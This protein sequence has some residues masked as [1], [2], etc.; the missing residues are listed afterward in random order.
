MMLKDREIRYARQR[1]G[2]CALPRFARQRAGAGG[3]RLPLPVCLRPQAVPETGQVMAS[4]HHAPFACLAPGFCLMRSSPRKLG[5]RK[6][7]VPDMD[8]WG[9]NEVNKIPFGSPAV[10]ASSVSYRLLR[11]PWLQQQTG[12]VPPVQS[13][14]TY[15]CGVRM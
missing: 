14:T 9:Q 5:L 15:M 3:C 11:G 12:R 1:A 7:W 6:V 2:R 10:L 8:S 13:E 4:R